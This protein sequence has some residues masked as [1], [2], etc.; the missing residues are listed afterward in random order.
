MTIAS[1][2][3]DVTGTFSNAP[4]MARINST[5]NLA[6]FQVSYTP[7]AVTLTSVDHA[8][9]FTGS[10]A[11][12]IAE[13]VSTGAPVGTVV[14]T[15]E[16]TVSYSLSTGSPFSIDSA[17]GQIT[18]TGSLDF[19]TQ[20]QYT[21]TATASDGVLSREA[22]ITIEVTNV[23]EDNLEVV[24]HFLTRPGGPFEGETDPA[25]IGFDADPDKDG[26]TNVFE[27]WIGSDPATSDASPA[28]PLVKVVDV[29]GSDFGAVEIS[30]VA[31]LDDVLGIETEASFDLNAWRSATSSRTVLSEVGG[32]RTLQFTDPSALPASDQKFYLRFAADPDSPN[33]SL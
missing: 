24:T 26:R 7:T 12:S 19:E 29:A 32:R 8:P 14:A 20:S 9:V 30:V 13:N 11:F 6:S 21:L 4:E 2:D 22:T 1:S 17:S 27:L 25:I 23:L 16:G 33:P 3:V 10:N 18:T 5:N 28:E 31:E 15:D